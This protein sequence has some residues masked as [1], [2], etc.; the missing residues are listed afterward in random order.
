[1][2]PVHAGLLIQRMRR[3]ELLADVARERRAMAAERTATAT[4]TPERT[5]IRCTASAVR[6]ALTSLGTTILK[7][8]IR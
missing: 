7:P 3:E 1:M 2:S 8:A 4:D 6:C 5:A